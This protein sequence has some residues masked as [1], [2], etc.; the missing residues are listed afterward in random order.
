[1]RNKRRGIA[2]VEAAVVL[3]ILLI[4]MLGVWEVGRMIQVDQVLTNSAREGARLAAGGYVNG[5][6]V[7]TAMVQRAVRDYM[8]ASGLPAAAASGATVTLTCLASPNWTDPSAALPL[9]RFQVTVVI[10]AGAAFNSLR[11]NV[12]NKITTISQMSVSAND[13]V[14]ESLRSTYLS[15]MVDFG[16]WVLPKPADLGMLLFN[17]LGAGNHFGP[18]LDPRTLEAHGFSM[19]LSVLSSLAFAAVV[20]FAS[21]RKFQ[22][23]D[24]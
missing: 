22:A 13:M 11:W 5:T 20:L 24:Y 9:D 15:G 21:A 18:L 2:A 12:L 7:T 16:Y 6:P 1:M 19:L 4:L 8:T 3:P 17:A 10:P 23:T 14:S